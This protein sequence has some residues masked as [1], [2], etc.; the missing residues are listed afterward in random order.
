MMVINFYF[1]N[2]LLNMHFSLIKASGFDTGKNDTKYNDTRNL[3]FK[4]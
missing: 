2:F 1:S 4:K 3:F